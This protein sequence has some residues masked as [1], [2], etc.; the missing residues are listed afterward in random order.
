MD[1]RGKCPGE[2]M[3][4]INGDR[5]CRKLIKC[6]RLPNGELLALLM[7]CPGGYM[8]NYELG[9]CM[10]ESVLRKMNFKCPGSTRSRSSWEEITLEEYE[11]SIK[12]LP[13]FYINR[14]LLD[15]HNNDQNAFSRRYGAIDNPDILFNQQSLT[16]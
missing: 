13:V 4:G 15:N 10:K 8:Y 3:Y 14:E 12:Q 1:E 16:L 9:K 2:G 7:R 5:G 11:E 6:A